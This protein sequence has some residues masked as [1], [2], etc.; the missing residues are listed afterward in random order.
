MSKAE[1]VRESID[2]RNK[3]F[4]EAL[5]SYLINSNKQ[6]Y[7]VE[8]GDQIVPL[9][10][11]INI[12][13]AILQKHYNGKIPENLEEESELFS[14]IIISHRDRFK[15]YDSSRDKLGLKL[16]EKMTEIDKESK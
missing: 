12:H 2:T 15:P 13:L 6:E 9:T 7:L 8:Y 1:K 16:K 10:S 11:K 5:K 3:S 4:P 14:Q